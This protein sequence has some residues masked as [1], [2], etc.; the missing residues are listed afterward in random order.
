MRKLSISVL[1]LLCGLV[2]CAQPRVRTGIDVLIEDDFAPLNGKRVG[3]VT[4]PTGFTSELHSTVDVLSRAK[5]VKLVALF[6]PEHGV[7]GDAY[8]GDKVAN[9][10]DAI[11]GL[12]VYSLYG[13]TRK[14]APEMLDG[15]DV[16][17]YDVQDIGSRSYTFIS[18]LALLMEAAAERG[19]AVVVLDRPNPLGGERIEGRPLD[20][21]FQSFVGQLPAPYLHGMTVGE[22][23]LMINGEGWLPEGA[24]CDLTVVA[25]DG[26]R[27]DMLFEDTGLIWVPTS[28]HVPRADS[29]FYYAASGI[30]GELRVFSEGVGY[31]LPFELIGAPGINAEAFADELN[32]RKLDGV[33]FR[34]IYYKPYYASY[35]GEL[36]GGVQIHITDKSKVNLTEIQFHA[37]DAARKLQ[38]GIQFFGKKRDGMFD[39]VCGTDRIR[40]LF[41]SGA[42]LNDVLAAWRDGVEE[43][44]TQ[45]R[46]YL[47]YK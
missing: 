10:T 18:T 27:R 7:R 41:E 34:P 23:A 19:I 17:V 36:C 46:P 24:K 44:R 30:L 16:M 2:G 47:L 20:L 22:L 39:K 42:P 4:N 9:T 15:I 40:E 33:V 28:P 5:G 43:F 11:T 29:S 37:M 1:V 13:A 8:A 26:W 38:P 35:K 32:R 45:R 6:G 21:K 31:T 14:A 3:L 25:M 12:P